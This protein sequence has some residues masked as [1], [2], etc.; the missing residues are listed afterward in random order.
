MSKGLP[1]GYRVVLTADR[2]LMADYAVLMDG[3]VAAAQT[4]GVPAWLMR[5]LISPPAPANGLRVRRAP[6]G[7]R[8]IEAALLRDGFSE[9]QVIIVAP[10]HLAKAVGPATRV[11]G[12]SSGDPLGRG[13]TTTTMEALAGGRAYTHYWFRALMRQIARLRRDY[14]FR[15]LFGGPGAWQLVQDDGAR[16]DL[17]ID[18]VFTGYAES[19]VA[20]VV[21]R[22][23]AN[24]ELRLV[25][26]QWTDVSSV[27][28]LRGPTIMGAVEISRGCGLGC[29]FCTIAHQRMCH[30]SPEAVAADVETNVR[31]GAHAVCLLSEDLFRYGAAGGALNPQALVGLIEHLKKAPARPLLQ[32]D[33][34]NV[35]SVAQYDDAA[36]RA[37]REALVEGVRHR[38]VWVNLGVET[39]S[40]A[41][42]A[43]N[44]GAAKIR[45]YR[46]DQWEAVAEESV[47]R[48]IAAGFLPM[49]SLLFGLP[50]ETPADIER[51]LRFVER[52]ADER[53]VIFPLFL[54]PVAP[55]AKAFGLGDMTALHW[56]LFRRCYALNFRWIP[57][58]YWDNQRAAGVPPARSLVLQAAGRAQTFQWKARFMLKA[59]RR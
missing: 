49:L 57:R 28:L 11:V 20:D 7:L 32:V 18:C 1:D 51:T 47:R 39:A 15:V 52:L 55:D 42:L 5:G 22:L 17:G 25:E 53:L 38:C 45:P 12:V 14:D 40:G 8:R 33:H 35:V 43:A 4:T 41:L 44:G 26:G 50:G 2:L 29:D 3:M 48:L 27:P 6:L 54:A 59:R 58:L 23:I 34:A 46:P 31:A 36:L 16:R 9:D 21:R 30:L 19:G 13:M 24:E 37:V 56:R 10:Q